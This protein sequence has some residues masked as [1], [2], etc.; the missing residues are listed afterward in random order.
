M[1]TTPRGAMAAEDATLVV[2]CLI[3]LVRG[4]FPPADSLVDIART[5]ADEDDPRVLDA[6]RRLDARAR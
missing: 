3:R 5:W 1:T 4:E 6:L 2:D